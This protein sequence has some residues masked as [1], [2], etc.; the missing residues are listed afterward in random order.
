[1]GVD[2]G[3]D[4]IAPQAPEPRQ[5]AILVRAGEARVADDI[6]DQNRRDFPGSRHGALSGAVQTSMKTG[7]SREPLSACRAE[8]HDRR[9]ALPPP[10]CRGGKCALIAE[11]LGIAAQ[12]PETRQGAI[13]AGYFRG[14]PAIQRS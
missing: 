4:E 8:A 2:G 7:L 3:I 5:R 12:V 9:C 10:L 6:R 11:S 14:A 13:L 1:M